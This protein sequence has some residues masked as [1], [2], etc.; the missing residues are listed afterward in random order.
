M[1]AAGLLACFVGGTLGVSHFLV[2]QP[3]LSQKRFPKLGKCA[4]CDMLPDLGHQP[5]HEAEVVYRRQVQAEDLLR[6]EK[7]TQVGAAEMLA[8]VTI[9]AW[10]DRQRIGGVAGVP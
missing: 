2:G 4:R 1:S 7:M 5:D 8:G 10:F 6:L 9:A 3:I